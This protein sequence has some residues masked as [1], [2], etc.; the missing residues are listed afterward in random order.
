ME[1]TQS[2]FPWVSN[3][4]ATSRVGHALAC[5]PSLH[6]LCKTVQARISLLLRNLLPVPALQPKRNLRGQPQFHR[7]RNPRLLEGP[8][9]LRT[10]FVA[11]DRHGGA[12]FVAAHHAAV[13]HQ[14][15]RAGIVQ[16]NR[17]VHRQFHGHTGGQ[18]VLGGEPYAAARYIQGLAGA[19]L[20]DALTVEHLVADLLLD[21]ETPFRAPFAFN[22]SVSGLVLW[23][24][25]DHGY[26]LLWQITVGRLRAQDVFGYL[27]G[28][29]GV[30]PGNRSWPHNTLITNKLHKLDPANPQ[31]LQGSNPPAGRRQ[32]KKF[33][34][35]ANNYGH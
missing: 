28:A 11:L 17:P 19:R 25:L 4:I 8:R 34:K 26:R 27:G 20:G 2:I 35:N 33:A 29:N 18:H 14:F 16:Q 1:T 15:H 23:L 6:V 10:E 12:P 3:W 5:P 22:E 13:N 32:Q 7:R 30:P 24:S 31:R 21:Q 9:T